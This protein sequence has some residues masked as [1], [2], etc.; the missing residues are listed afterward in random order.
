[1]E[2]VVGEP[3]AVM[4]FP[5][6]NYAM[7]SGQPNASVDCPYV[8]LEASMMITQTHHLFFPTYYDYSSNDPNDAQAHYTPMWLPDGEYTPVTH[9]GGVW[10][11]IGEMTAVV[12]QGQCN[13]AVGLYSNKII[14]KGS[15]YDDMYPNT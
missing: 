15:M 10:S 5:E 2:G 7:Q 13:P 6:F 14:I 12:T 9:I 8:A 1:M 4:T 3:Y 11:P